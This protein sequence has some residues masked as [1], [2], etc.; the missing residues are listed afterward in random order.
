MSE[1]FMQRQ[2]FESYMIRILSDNFMRMIREKYLILVWKQD[3][4]A[5]SFRTMRVNLLFLL[6]KINARLSTY[7]SK[8]AG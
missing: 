4:D 7:T 2:D 1:F 3:A 6:L 5:A 8:I